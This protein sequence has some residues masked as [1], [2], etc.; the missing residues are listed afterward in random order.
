MASFVDAIR[1]IL[2]KYN[3]LGQY[4]CAICSCKVFDRKERKKLMIKHRKKNTIKQWSQRRKK[5][6]LEKKQ[7]RDMKNKQEIQ[8]KLSQKYKTVDTG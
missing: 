3:T 7:F 8:K 6:S 5:I 2:E 4:T 1:K